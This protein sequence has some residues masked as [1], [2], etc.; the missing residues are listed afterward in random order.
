MG[1]LLIFLFGAIGI[2]FLCSVL[3]ACLL[4]A[5][6]SFITMKEEEGDRRAARLKA[7]K[8]DIDKPI[9]AILSL[10]TIAHTVGAAGVGAQATAIWGDEYF[11]LVSAVMTFLILVLSEI[12]PKTIGANYWRSLVLPAT[13]VIRGMI[14]IMYPLVL[15][16]ELITKILPQSKDSSVS[17]EEVSAMVTAGVEEGTF[18]E[19]ESEIINNLISLEDVKASE[20]MTPRVVCSIASE[21][22][23]VKEYYNRRI[24]EQKSKDKAAK[25]RHSRIPVYNESDEYITGYVL[26]HEILE[27]LA[28]DSFDVR[29]SE[30]KR[31]ILYFYEETP[32]TEILDTLLSHKEHI[33]MIINE[34]GCFQGIITMEDIIETLLGLEI[35]DEKDEIADLAQYAKEKWEKKREQEN[36][37]CAAAVSKPQRAQKE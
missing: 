14:W 24:R 15:L 28:S 3:E 17:R 21:K 31:D 7:Y 1:L 2:S 20:I 10:N 6:T 29:L 19:D 8:Q 26:R 16:S 23:T 25:M 18:D 4:S 32:V 37:E 12:I 27:L 35:L 30:I 13:S 5:P 33:A 9:S 11:G 36:I 22:M 34:Y